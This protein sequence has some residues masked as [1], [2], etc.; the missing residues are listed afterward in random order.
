MF[1]QA[2]AFQF[3]NAVLTV[4]SYVIAIVIG[5]GLGWALSLFPNIVTDLKTVTSITLSTL[6]VCMMVVANSIRMA[7]GK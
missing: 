2:L 6:T 5:L 7:L 4:I 1:T 3:Q